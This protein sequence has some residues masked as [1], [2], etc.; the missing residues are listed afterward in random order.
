MNLFDD[1]CFVI[2]IVYNIFFYDIDFMG[3]V[4]YG[5]YFCYFEIV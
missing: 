3:V 5:N 2:W 1:L 4:W